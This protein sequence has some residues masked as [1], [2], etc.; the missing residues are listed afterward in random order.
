[1]T[2][3]YP[4]DMKLYN[5][6]QAEFRARSE[7]NRKILLALYDPLIP[8]TRDRLLTPETLIK[9]LRER[10]TIKFRCIYELFTTQVESVIREAEG[11]GQ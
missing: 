4:D 11:E 10:E 8:K 3:I 7:Y 5:R 6:T 2:V 9:L 1:M